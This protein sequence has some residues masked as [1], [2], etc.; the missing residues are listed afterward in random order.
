MKSITFTIILFL[1]SM[2]SLSQ[3]SG[4]IE[5]GL[6]VKLGEDIEE[7]VKNLKGV[8]DVSLSE[9]AEKLSFVL[10]FKNSDS[11]FYLVEGIETK[12]LDAKMALA[13]SR[14]QNITYSNMVKKTV[15]HNNKKSMFFDENEF[16]IEKNIFDSWELK[17]EKKEIQGFL[18]Y[19]A[20]GFN[21]VT[22]NK[23]EEKRE[24]VAW[25][26]PELPF[27]F[28]PNGYGGLPGLILELQNENALFG[29]TK[30]SLNEKIEDIDSSKLKGKKITA[31]EYSKIL[32]ERAGVIME[33]R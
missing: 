14:Y 7:V 18:C 26:C 22:T 19:K 28:G 32:R 3:K 29:V 5:Y 15:Y 31:E 10:E 11:K 8:E 2:L 24:V 13:W 17:N 21:I 33:G 25:Y 16:V 30:V 9:G 4:K 6:F 20:V 1:T 27:S 23:G 12:D